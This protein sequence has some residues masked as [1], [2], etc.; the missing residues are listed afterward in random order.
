MIYLGV[1]VTPA[2]GQALALL[3][4]VARINEFVTKHGGK[5]TANFA[6]AIGG[7]GSGDHVHLFA[8]QDWAA[9][10]AAAEA[11]QADAEW[12]KMLADTGTM[13]ASV[14]LSVLQP[15]PESALQ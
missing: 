5:A 4:Y 6:V 1:R 10:G 15:L 9:Y 14:S 7:Q 2:P 11:L 13:V 12:L 8:Y 3:P